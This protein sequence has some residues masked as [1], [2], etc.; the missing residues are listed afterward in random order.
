MN[1]KFW[2]WF[3]TKKKYVYKF[4]CSSNECS[5][6]ETCTKPCEKIE[7]DDDK[8]KDLFLKYKVCPDCGSKSFIEGSSGG[9]AMNIKCKECG[10]WFNMGLPLFIQRINV[11][12]EKFYD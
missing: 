9:S 7:M 5:V 11:T 12:N 6:R 2:N 3:K 1:Y 4:P 10:H 8:L